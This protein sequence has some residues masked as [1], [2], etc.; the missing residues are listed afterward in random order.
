M[1]LGSKK[2]PPGASVTRD[3]AAEPSAAWVLSLT[4]IFTR[5]S[6]ISARK[7][8]VSVLHGTVQ[9]QALAC[10]FLNISLYGELRSIPGPRKG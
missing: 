2:E 4:F 3:N 5:H 6:V 10:R 8:E 9:M 7:H 1:V